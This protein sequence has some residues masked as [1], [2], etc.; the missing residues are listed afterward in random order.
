MKCRICGNEANISLKAYN[1]GLCS[2]DFISFFEKQVAVTI[3]KYT[4]FDK[5]DIPLVAVS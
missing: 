1:I 3:R 4:L 2:Q 5:G